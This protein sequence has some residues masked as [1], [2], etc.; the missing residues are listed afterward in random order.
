[1]PRALKLLPLI[2]LFAVPLFPSVPAATA[3]DLSVT[4]PKKSVRVVHTRRARVVRDYDGA[5]IVIRRIVVR[6]GDAQVVMS[7][8]EPVP[9]AEPSRYL[10][11]QP[12]WP[13]TAVRRL[14]FSRF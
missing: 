8:T 2:A 3:A 5:P 13:T 7:A 10:N 6:R 12:V 1:M 14:R 4:S 11:G 9:R